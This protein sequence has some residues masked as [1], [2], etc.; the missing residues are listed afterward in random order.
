[1]PLT[2]KCIDNL[3]Q[4]ISIV[5]VVSQSISLRQRGTRYWGLSPFKAEKTPSFCVNPERNT[6]YCFSTSQGGDVIRFVM[7]TEGLTF[8]EA[9]SKLAQRYGIPLEYEQGSGPS[10]ETRSLRQ[11][12][13]QLHEVAAD[14]FHQC[15][16]AK[17]REGEEIRSY[18]EH[19]R[20]FP[21]EAA[22]RFKI[23]YASSQGRDLLDTLVR[24]GFSNEALSE[25]GLFY[26]GKEGTIRQAAL[27][28]PRFRG[29]LMI[30]IRNLQGEIVAFTAR[31]THLTPADDYTIE[32]KYVNSPETILFRK[33]QVVFLLDRANKAAREKGKFLVVEG[34]LDAIRCWQEGFSHV[35]A[36]QGSAV[37]PE[38]LQLLRRFV[39]KI[40]C[41]LDGDEAGQ[42]AAL[43]LLPLALQVGL[44]PQFIILPTQ[45]DPDSLLVR[46]GRS[47]L[48]NLLEHP[49][50]TMIFAAK[51]LLPHPT[52]SPR[53][54]TD[55][56][57]RIFE[58][59]HNCGET[60]LQ[61]A[62]LEQAI[63]VLGLDRKAV[64]RDF[65]SFSR[66]KN[67]SRSLE[68]AAL[69]LDPPIKESEQLTTAESDLLYF[70]LHDGKVGTA[71]AGFLNSDWIDTSTLDGRI[72]SR[73]LAEIQENTHEHLFEILDQWDRED[74][75]NRM[76]K[77]LAEERVF[78][79]RSAAINECLRTLYV[80]YHQRIL[81]SIN[82]QTARLK[83]NDPLYRDLV[84]RRIRLRHAKVNPPNF[85]QFLA[86]LG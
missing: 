28:R 34:Q 21:I 12:I 79:N 75:R 31:K 50:P 60:S 59:L 38:Q 56:C 67:Q 17:N 11:E 20:H 33:S 65:E 32:A 45:D 70:V 83:T 37:T 42:K 5:E 85:L 74:E 63:T 46:E 69:L 78:E 76:H 77:L 3:R 47:S 8:P 9:C 62:Y 19:K 7:E 10:A 16:L 43:R 81:D 18:W 66:Q 30:P 4:R 36:F 54:R 41:L 80:K 53:D 55:A 35:V 23:G 22:E 58:I 40:D 1:M 15:F 84:N 86:S 39:G 24:K 51:S 25:S 52:A 64:L 49:I 44:E 27:L 48:L 29:R 13:L 6:Y 72:L 82:Q 61:I 73:L 68:K 71:I 14:Y 57:Q 26:D 2:Q